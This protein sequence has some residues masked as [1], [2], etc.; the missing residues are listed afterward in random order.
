MSVALLAMA[1]SA[2]VMGTAEF[3]ITGLLPNVAGDLNLSIPTAG[4]LISGYA[5]AVV[6]GGPACTMAGARV[7]RKPLLL[8]AMLL[9]VVGNLVSAVAPAYWVLM[10]GRVLAAFGQAS[11]LGI[12]TVV[13]ANLVADHLRSRA[14]AMVF[15]GITL[16]NVAGAPLGTLLGQNLGWRTIF[17]IISLAAVIS[18]LGVAAS[19]PPQPSPGHIGFRAE[20]AMFGRKQVWLTLAI[21]MFAMGAVFAS[22]SYIAPLLTEVTELSSAAI[23]PMLA[24]FGV[25]L[26]AGNL[27]GGWAAD[28]AQLPT[29]GGA[30]GLLTVVML[31]FAALSHQPVAVAIG[32][33]LTG[34]AGFA[35]IP[36]FLARLINLAG[37]ESPLSAATGGSA[38]NMGIA[39]GAYLGGLTIQAGFGYVAPTWL[40]AVL[41]AL[42]L[43]AV[44]AVVV[45]RTPV[46]NT[47]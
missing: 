31:V 23:T 20:L 24:L 40:G 6:I 10:V 37:G 36:A 47:V 45:S 38:S 8:A 41:A 34:A 12:G 14:I 27:L 4:T 17:W 30:L 13:A 15:S 2:F 25:G 18:L 28:R 46:A 11:F 44:L 35:V 39:A 26:V 3:V 9:F 7:P 1:L 29:L 5:L 16:A 42:G 21:G 43:G 33:V 32:L 22:F 19:V